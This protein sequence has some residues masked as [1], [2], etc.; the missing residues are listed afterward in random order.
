[1]KTKTPQD[2]EELSAQDRMIEKL[3]EAIA[4]STT[5]AIEVA[6][7]IPKKNIHTRAKN[8]PWTTKDEDGKA[9]P[10]LKLKRKF[11]QHNIPVDEKIMSNTEI[12]LANRLK[13]GQYC[14]NFVVVKRRQDKGI[15]ITY[16]VKTASQRLKLMNE[17]GIRSLAELLQTCIAESKAPKKVE[18]EDLED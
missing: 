6:R 1:M 18:L 10:K 13:P 11:Y 8:T 9:V 3:A 12:D 7:P 17:F 15:N 14:D 4:R 2:T 5:A 16:P